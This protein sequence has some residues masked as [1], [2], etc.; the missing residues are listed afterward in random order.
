MDKVNI[1]DC[2]VGDKSWVCPVSTCKKSLSR[3]QTLRTHL[4]SQHGIDG[5][6]H[7]VHVLL[8][9]FELHHEKTFFLY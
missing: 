4:L 7:K 8:V 5:M 9:P 1:E 3:K 2:Q 6:F